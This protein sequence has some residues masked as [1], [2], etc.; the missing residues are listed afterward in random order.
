MK[1]I[2]DGND[3][4][5]N[6][7][8]Y[9]YIDPVPNSIRVPPKREE[10]TPTTS[11]DAAAHNMKYCKFCAALIPIDAVICTSCGRQVEELKIN[12][13]SVPQGI[14][15]NNTSS[16]NPNVH[17]EGAKVDSRIESRSYPHHHMVTGHMK[18]KWV[19]LLLCMFFGYL[20]IHKFYEE[21]TGLGVL[22]LFMFMAMIGCVILDSPFLFIFP[23]GFLSIG[24]LID[25]ILILVKPNPYYV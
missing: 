20:G 5:D 13:T 8:E 3:Q 10:I 19:T 6:Q 9:E 11:F 16:S 17:V 12:N 14:T 24:L 18:N 1:N 22:Y 15:I 2:Y 25:F 7:I 23:M 21:K 4:Q